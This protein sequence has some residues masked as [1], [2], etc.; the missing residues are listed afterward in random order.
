MW[1]TTKKLGK[2]GTPLL[3]VLLVAG[4]VLGVSAMLYQ[5]QV[6]TD[7]VKA[8]QFKSNLP[9]DQNRPIAIIQGTT[10][11]GFYLNV[12]NPDTKPMLYTLST[13]ITG[14]SGVTMNLDKPPYATVE[15]GKSV[16]WT[17]SFTCDPAATGSV[18]IL[19]TVYQA[20]V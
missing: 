20:T 6:R 3:A 1:K 4:V 9:A 11:S 7:I 14:G 8:G 2:Y 16:N 19:Y 10:V 13:E 12:T 18:W 15:S 17:I 5:G